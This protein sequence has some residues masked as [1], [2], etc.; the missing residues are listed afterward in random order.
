MNRLIGNRDRRQVWLAILLAVIMVVSLSAVAT[1]LSSEGA[2][3][4]D[5]TG[6]SPVSTTEPTSEDQVSCDEDLLA[7]TAS[8]ES[9]AV[10][11]SNSSFLADSQSEATRT[12]AAEEVNSSLVGGSSASDVSPR[13]VFKDVNGSETVY[14]NGVE[15]GTTLQQ[16]LQ[17]ENETKMFL[18]L[19]PVDVDA[20]ID[21]IESDAETPSNAE[22][23]E[24]IQ[25]EI[26][27]IQ[28]PVVEK[29]EG[30]SDVEVIDSYWSMNAIL[31]SVNGDDTVKTTENI[32]KIDPIWRMHNDHKI[33]YEIEEK[34]HAVNQ[35]HQPIPT[36]YQQHSEYTW[37]L[38]M[39]NV[40]EIRSE[41]DFDGAE[42]GAGVDVA[43]LDTGVDTDHPDLSVDGWAEFSGLSD[44]NSD[45]HECEVAVGNGHG[46]H[47]S[48]IVSG[49]GTT[50]EGRMYGVAPEVNFHHGG[51]MMVESE[52]QCRPALTQ[53]IGDIVAGI[54]WAYEEQDADV[55]SMSLG[56]TGYLDAV[57]DDPFQKDI[58]E[59]LHTVR[60]AGVVPIGSA[61]NDGEG[62]AST[63]G[64]TYDDI[65]VGM[66]GEFGNVDFRSGGKEI[67][68]E[69][70]WCGLLGCPDF[71]DDWPATYTVPDV[72]APGVSVVSAAPTEHWRWEDKYRDGT[73]TSMAAPHVAGA[74]AILL[75]M[76]FENELGPND[77]H[78]V[79]IE[80]ADHPESSKQDN[81]YGHGIVDPYAAIVELW[82]DAALSDENVAAAGE[83]NQGE[84]VE[85][86]VV[87]ENTGDRTHEF[88]VGHSVFDSA[89]KEY[90]NDDQ[91]GTTVELAP[92]ESQQVSIPWVVEGDSGS[93]VPVDTYDSQITVWV[94][95]DR[96]NLMTPIETVENEGAFEVVQEDPEESTVLEASPDSW[97]LG[98]IFPGNSY[99]KSFT[100]EN[101]GEL[102]TDVSVSAGSGL[103][104]SGEPDKIESGESSSFSVTLDAD[105]Y[106]GGSL[107]IAYD[108]GTFS[109]PISAT[110]VSDGDLV[111]DD[112][113]SISDPHFCIWGAD[114]W[115]ADYPITCDDQDYMD[116]VDEVDIDEEAIDGFQS[117]TLTVEVATEDNDDA[118]DNDVEVFVNGEHITDI[119][120]PPGGGEF[121]T[122][123]ISL[124]ERDLQKGG[125]EIKLTTSGSS[126]YKIG[127]DTRLD[128]EYFK[129]PELDLDF[130]A[131][132]E[133]VEV[134]ETFFLPVTVENEGGRV[135][136]DV[137]FGVTDFDGLTVE[138]WP[139]NF[140][141][142][143][144][145]DLEPLEVDTGYFEIKLEEETTASGTIAV[146][147]EGAVF[148]E[149][150]SFTV[151]TPNNPPT[152]DSQGIASMDVYPDEDVTY[153]ATVTDPDDSDIDV[154][155]EAY[156]PSDETWKMIDTQTVSGS[157]TATFTATPFDGEDIGGTAQYRFEY[158]DDFGNSGT[159]GPYAGPAVEDPNP[160]GPSF[161][162]WSYPTEIQPEQDIDVQVD[163]SDPAGI[164]SAE[165][166]YTKPGETEESIEMVEDEDNWTATIPA[167]SEEDVGQQ[168]EF[169]LTATD[170]HEYSKTSQSITRYISIE[171]SS[172]PHFEVDIIETNSPFETGETL[173][174]TAEI[175]NKGDISDTQTV[176]L[177][178]GELGNGSTSVSLSGGGN[179]TETFAISTS[180]GDSGTYTATVESDNDSESTTVEAFTPLP[181][182]ISFPIELDRNVSSAITADD[183][184]LYATF[185]KEG[186]DDREVGKIDPSTEEVIETFD[187]PDGGGSGLTYN[188]GYLW[189]VD[190]HSDQ[191][192]RINPETGDTEVVFQSTGVPT[193]AG[194]GEKALWIGNASSNYVHKYTTDGEEISRFYT[195]SEAASVKSVAYHDDLIWVGD[196]DENIFVYEPTGELVEQHSV[197]TSARVGSS[198]WGVL[199]AD[200]EQNI[201][202]LF[203]TGADPAL[204]NVTIEENESTTQVA[205][206]ETIVIEATIENTG[207]TAG[208]QNITFDADGIKLNSTAV[209]LAGGEKSTERVTLEVDD[210]FDSEELQVSS[211][212]DND[213]VELTVESNN[214]ED[215]EI[216][217]FTIVSAVIAMITGG[218]YARMRK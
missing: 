153:T 191:V 53:P 69:E 115:G 46:T 104:I 196:G 68:T 89:G 138:G 160:K 212:D 135:A 150:E 48:G 63:P 57:F 91:T 90:T 106:G 100:I 152:I 16:E 6:I 151:E 51:V 186:S 38:E 141:P 92:G 34:A 194:F 12:P 148:D 95:S 180:F 35:S 147:R 77:I 139:A 157:G 110:I 156:L 99:D 119:E 101:T 185:E 124:S 73:G 83:Y 214:E 79:L 132:P 165:L 17:T 120:S 3:E 93:K 82:I 67:D 70:A 9:E 182:I 109:I 213:T 65:S 41:F 146:D 174:V 121:E 144:E 122:H 33:R 42:M 192:T 78:E 199:V 123:T 28:D 47:V 159:W 87:V 125:N 80:T 136:E 131:H 169:F 193:G 45:P 56:G 129:P 72:T 170:D 30:K 187:I 102:D 15:V 108:G 114:I 5:S 88:F 202:Q 137:R 4:V 179:T 18:R 126:A 198:H 84:T 154:T 76:D 164:D 181:P 172:D 127:S 118:Q 112:W 140:S 163:L 14:I 215:D 49:D 23:A 161:H 44:P 50:D 40:P 98:S 188:E 167:P 190:S 24:A 143:E 145:R 85:A 107:T 58:A 36:E 168:I 26:D 166:T 134:G 97:D 178:A 66:V 74:A 59:T 37:A 10:N 206:N 208:T 155:L 22:I 71:T 162:G 183:E 218:I 142:E 86:S 117:A 130:G 113:E 19:N 189:T 171:E 216:P 105:D 200:K 75:G 21:Q 27:T 60:S 29:L 8:S 205:E 61:G 149:D 204:F 55:I 203:E 96:D 195:G 52:E 62:S 210:S 32:T 158:E 201:E 211:E 43:V 31:V 111:D 25:R 64:N 13:Q 39:L 133:E 81:R 176:S 217:G 103:S 207:K 7:Q 94:E 209:S 116:W 175:E 173:E 1:G 197:D 20:I 184:F 177:D 54:E 11:K 128:W 2:N